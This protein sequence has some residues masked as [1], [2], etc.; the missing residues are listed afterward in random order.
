MP[1][2]QMPTCPD[3]QDASM[4]EREIG[5][6]TVWYFCARCGLMFLLGAAGEVLRVVR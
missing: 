6:R 5:R 2:A 1:R 4:V 3:C